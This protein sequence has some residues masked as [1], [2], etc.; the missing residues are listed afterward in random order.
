MSHQKP[1]NFFFY[2][3]TTT[4]TYTWKQIYAVP[5][6]NEHVQENSDATS[7]ASGDW[8]LR[9]TQKK[10]CLLSREIV[11]RF[12]FFLH[13]V[14]FFFCFKANI[15]VT[16]VWGY[17]LYM[18]QHALTKQPSFICTLCAHVLWLV[19]WTGVLK[20]EMNVILRNIYAQKK[21]DLKFS[22]E[23]ANKK[24]NKGE[25]VTQSYFQFP[26]NRC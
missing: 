22:T 9:K 23:K 6:Q 2:V 11:L 13:F 8:I 18:Q 4:N 17:K 10:N 19:V 16:H 21:Q 14:S 12:F 26:K 25:W 5:E 7:Q 24:N 20:N 15:F 3:Q 1:N